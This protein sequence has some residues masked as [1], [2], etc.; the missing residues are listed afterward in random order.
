MADKIPQKAKSSISKATL[1][2]NKVAYV[3]GGGPSLKG[4]DFSQLRGRPCYAANKSAFFVPWGFLIST[5]RDFCLN[6]VPE[7]EDFGERAFLS[8]P[9][10]MHER[11][12]LP[13]ARNANYL[14]RE[15]CQKVFDMEDGTLAGLNSGA[16][17]FAKALFDGYKNIALLGI[18]MLPKVGHFHDGYKWNPHGI[19]DGIIGAWISQFEV[20]AEEAKKRGGYRIINFSPDSAVQG[21]EKRPL[22]ELET[23]FKDAP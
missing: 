23:A 1:P 5:D 20:A 2:A 3:I 22:S 10:N 15:K 11:M 8:P 18:D 12:K 19:N 9:E 14:R 6:C 7:I 16:A 4:F 21:F 13:Y 17:A